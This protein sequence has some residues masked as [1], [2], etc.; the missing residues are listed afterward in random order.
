MNIQFETIKE[1]TISVGKRLKE[2]AGTGIEK[3]KGLPKK[4]KIIVCTIAVLAVLLLIV[5]FG[6]AGGKKNEIQTAV[7]DR[8]NISVVISGTGTIKPIDEYEVTSLVKGEILSDTFQEGDMVEKGD[9]L[10]QI[11]SS[12]LENTLEK[13]QLNHQ[14]TQLSYNQTMR[15]LAKLNVKSTYSGTI[16]ETY[17]KVGDSVN[18]GTKIADLVDMRTMRLELPFNESDVSGIYVGSS[19]QVTLA[20]SLYTLTGKVT[21]IS[22]GSLV[23]AEGAKVKTVEIE[24]PNPG[25]ILPGEMATAIIGDVACN[26]P[27]TLEYRLKTSIVAETAGDVVSMP[28]GKG[29][30]VS[31]GTVVAVLSSS[32]AGTTRQNSEISLRDSQLTVDN[33]NKQLEDYQITAPISGTVLKKT[34]KAGDTL[35]NTNASVVMAVI[36]DMSTIVFEMNVDELDISKIKVGQQ[37]DITAD[38]IE[39]R[40]YNGYVDYV[41]VV[42]TTQNGVT[43]YP[44]TI[45]VEQPEGLIPGM[46]VSAEIAVAS[47]E[48]VLRVPVTAVNRGNFVYVKGQKKGGDAVPKGMENMI[49]EGFS[50]VKVET[51]LHD[52]DYIE[53][54]SGLSEGDEVYIAVSNTSDNPFAAMMGAGGGAPGGGGNRPGG[55]PG[56][57]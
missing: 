23:S 21:R 46:N 11:D 28:R 1:K 35:D 3:F 53:I 33:Y 54:R 51:G 2:L 8:G 16:T 32:S 44:I 52:A 34:S 10:Y 4:K 47:C 18:I 48:N 57:R 24:V 26:G 13:A 39:G 15:D 6:K 37:V 14:K 7:A 22:S 41:S 42:G 27:G 20:N 40:T 12:D 36:A 49:P 30:S 56:G 19:A 31:A 25:A 17:V 9:L 29:D 45:V 55:T 43:T 50:A 38:A 5:L